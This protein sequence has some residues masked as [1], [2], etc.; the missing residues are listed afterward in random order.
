MS[1]ISSYTS[2][3]SYGNYTQTSVRQRPSE[4]DMAAM[5]KELFGKADADG[6][7][8][9]SK[10]ELSD[11][12]SKGPNGDSIDTEQA[13]ASFDADGDGNVTEDEMDAGMKSLH[14]QMESNMNKIRFGSDSESKGHGMGKPPSIEE[15]FSKADSSGDSA[16]S[17][18][19]FADF[20]SKGPQADSVDAEKAF[21]EYDTDGDGSLSSDEFKSGMKDLMASMPPPPPPPSGGSNSESSS[22]DSKNIMSS[23]DADGDG[24][25]DEEELTSGLSSTKI[26]QMISAYMKQMS[27]SYSTQQSD[28]LS[29]LSA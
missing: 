23:L 13:F 10:T 15:M 1:A 29:F 11:L 21:A 9:L 20:L 6:S 7:G 16:I 22:S 3:S 24:T 14:S 28:S 2:S 17:Q 26:Q 27:S 5:K 4:E 19:E 12:L 18:T 25:I 8:G